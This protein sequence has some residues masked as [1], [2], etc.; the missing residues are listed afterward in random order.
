[1]VNVLA[2]D[3]ETVPDVESG[4]RL[5]GLHGLS[6]ADVARVMRQRRL[7]ASGTEFMRHH[8][9]RIVAIAAVLRLF[10]LSRRCEGRVGYV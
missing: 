5:L 2:F 1:M 4:R 6:D 7:Q 9:N 3:I 10:D 8:L